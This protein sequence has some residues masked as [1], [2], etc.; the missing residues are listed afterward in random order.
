MTATCG[1]LFLSAW[2]KAEPIG[3]LQDAPSTAFAAYAF[4]FQIGQAEKVYN[5]AYQAFMVRPAADWQAWGLKA[6]QLVCAHYGL[7][8]YQDALRGEFWGCAEVNTVN[9]LRKLAGHTEE[10]SPRWHQMRAIFC[11]IP[12]HLVDVAYHERSNFG[13]RCEPSI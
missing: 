10:N 6:M 4:G 3:L 12:E 13:A 5:S 9:K 11:G 7:H 1:T 8:L 2:H